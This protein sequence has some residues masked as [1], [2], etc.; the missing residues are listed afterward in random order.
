MNSNKSLSIIVPCFNES[1]NIELFKKKLDENNYQDIGIISYAAKYASNFYAPFR[2]LVGSAK[3][4]GVAD[5]KNY[6]MDFR[7][8][9]EALREV[10]LDVGEG[11]DM[12][13]IKPGLPYLD[14]IAKVKEI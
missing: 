10:A 1:K 14:I 7:N 2:Q 5:K 6:Q 3:N 13:I 11:A 9:D 12:L 4:L 8:S